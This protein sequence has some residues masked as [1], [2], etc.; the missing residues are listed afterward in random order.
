[1][2]T[3]ANRDRFVGWWPTN[4]P[5]RITATGRVRPGNSRPRV[6]PALMGS[7]GPRQATTGVHTGRGTAHAGVWRSPC[8]SVHGKDPD[9]R[10]HRRPCGAVRPTAD[11]GRVTDKSSWL[12][13]NRLVA[14]AV[15]GTAPRPNVGSFHADPPTPHSVG[16]RHVA[17]SG[18]SCRRLG[19]GKGPLPSASRVPRR[20]RPHRAPGP[21]S[22]PV[23]APTS[24]EILRGVPIRSP[25][26]WRVPPPAW[27][28][29]LR[30]R[31]RTCGGVGQASHSPR[32]EYPSPSGLGR[33]TYTIS[34]PSSH[35]EHS[36][37]IAEPPPPLGYSEAKTKFVYPKWI[38]KCGPLS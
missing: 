15:L 36:Q 29:A 19:Q 18:L 4:G 13:A 20:R 24:P 11:R 3:V 26:L 31:G 16:A 21:P 38:S 8:S 27:D 35:H 2:S 7:A 28:G 10:P 30:G 12:T 17:R 6:P 25:G 23:I 22:K 14:Q 32:M 37:A 33:A 1:M 5:G 9:P 34:R